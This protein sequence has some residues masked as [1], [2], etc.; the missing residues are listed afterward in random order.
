M[1]VCHIICLAIKKFNSNSFGDNL[2]RSGDQSIE[3]NPVEN[4]IKRDSVL[5]EFLLLNQ[6]NTVSNYHP[7]HSE[8]NDNHGDGDDEEDAFVT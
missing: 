8:H 2:C 7:T 4:K 5:I 3:F 6:F 1:C